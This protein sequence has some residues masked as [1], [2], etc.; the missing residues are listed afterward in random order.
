MFLLLKPERG[1]LFAINTYQKNTYPYEEPTTAKGLHFIGLIFRWL[2][3]V[4]GLQWYDEIR[5]D[6]VWVS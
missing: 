4:Q 1:Y 3:M 6:M 5:Y 2:E